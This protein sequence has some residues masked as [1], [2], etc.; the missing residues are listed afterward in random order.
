MPTFEKKKQNKTKQNIKLKF[1]LLQ[2]TDRNDVY[3]W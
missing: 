3:I 2:T 1:P